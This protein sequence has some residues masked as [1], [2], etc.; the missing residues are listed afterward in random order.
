MAASEAS[1]GKEQLMTTTPQA[2]RGDPPRR[3]WRETAERGLYR[4]HR[5]ACPSSRDRKPGRRCGC[6]WELAVP[7]SAPGSTRIVTFTGTISQ[8]RMERRRL[9]VEGR[10]D[11]PAPAPSIPAGTL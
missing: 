9:L 4:A 6:P 3:G 8:A 10:P 1:D 5:L 2:A 11:P 7:G